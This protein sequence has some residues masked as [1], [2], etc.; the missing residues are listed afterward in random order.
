MEFGFRVRVRERCGLR[1]SDQGKVILTLNGPTVV[2]SNSISPHDQPYNVVLTVAICGRRGACLGV[3]GG[4]ERCGCV[5]RCCE[6]RRTTAVAPSHCA[7]A[8]V[9][10]A[11]GVQRPKVVPELVN[12]N[13]CSVIDRSTGHVHQ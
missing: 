4:E 2:Q 1:G 5:G 7:A 3:W 12:E 9:A 10:D 11:A 8:C 6:K 13:T